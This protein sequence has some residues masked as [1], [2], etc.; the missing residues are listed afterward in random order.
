MPQS[1]THSH[2]N[3][4]DRATRVMA[5]RLP[6]SDIAALDRFARHIGCTA[7]QVLKLAGKALADGRVAIGADEVRVFE[8]VA[9]ELRQ[10]RDAV[11]RLGSELDLTKGVSGSALDDAFAKLLAAL[12]AFETSARLFADRRRSIAR[13]AVM[14]AAGSAA[15]TGAGAP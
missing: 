12:T 11:E 6:P 4:V 9:H 8:A 3:D 1:I 10:A 2:R 15:E 7:P 14:A 13:A 5:L